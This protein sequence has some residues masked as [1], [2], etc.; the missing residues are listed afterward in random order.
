MNDLVREIVEAQANDPALWFIAQTAPEAY[1][2]KELRRLHAAVEASAALEA[3]EWIPVSERT[4][5]EFQEVLLYHNLGDVERPGV[6]HAIDVASYVDGEWIFPWDRGT[7]NP[8][9]RW[10]QY[11]MPLPAAPD[12]AGRG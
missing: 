2:Q 3:R 12:S 8:A 5:E 11:W 10:P 7:L 6:A 4:P 9:P 1:L